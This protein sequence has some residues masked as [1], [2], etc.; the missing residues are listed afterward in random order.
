MNEMINDK[1]KN[2]VINNKNIILSITLIVS[3]V[4][5]SIFILKRI[6]K[7]DVVYQSYAIELSVGDI[8]EVDDI[9][10]FTWISSNN[11]IAVIDNNYIKAK[12]KGTT[13]ITIYKNKDVVC[14]YVVKVKEKDVSNNLKLTTLEILTN[15]I[16]IPVDSNYELE[17][18]V[19]P[20]NYD[21]SK[22]YWTISDES[23]ATIINGVVTG[24]KEGNC[25]ISV[26]SNNGLF[27]SCNV[28]V[29]NNKKVES[30]SLTETDK[31]IYIGEG[32]QIKASIVPEDIDVQITYSSSNTNIATVSNNGVVKG[33][34]EGSTEITVSAE[35][36]KVILKLNVMKKNKE[37]TATFNANGAD[38]VG[39]SIEKCNSSNDECKI[40]MPS[41]N[42]N[43]YQVI[44]WSKDKNAHSA[45]YKVGEKVTIY[46]N[47]TYYAITYKTLT[48][49][50][51]SNR[52]VISKD[53]ETCNIYN[54]EQT[55]NIQTPSISRNNYSVIGWGTSSDASKAVA[56]SNTTISISSPSSYYALTKINTDGI[57]AG[58]TGWL[59]TNS[60]YY[61]SASRGSSKTSISV[62][63]AF[64]I[65]GV[66]GDFFKVSVPN[67]SGYKYIEYK[68]V[69]INLSDYIP[70]MYFEIANASSSIYKSSGYNLPGVTGTKLYAT[71]KLY[72][73]RLRKSEY[74]VPI[75]YIVAKKLLVAQR[76][77]QSQGYSIKV[78]DTYR[79]RSV[80]SKIYSSLTNLYDSNQVVRENILYSYGL[81]GTRYTWGKSW[82]LAPGVSKHNTGSAIDMTLVY[83]ST[84]VEV[85]MPTPMH[86]LSTKAI[87]YYAPGISLI[88]A[89]YS[90]EMNDVAKIMD[91]V[92]TKAGLTT[93][94]SEW[95]HFQD[96]NAHSIIL[97][98]QSNGCDFSVTK[99]YS[100]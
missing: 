31:K 78:Y 1:I 66:E 40:T 88:P 73:S 82:F 8:Y 62:G 97:E 2:F 38:N 6:S 77:L 72:N 95:W 60:Y 33:I 70:S 13:I 89:N 71:G 16:T 96:S 84:G 52:A 44:G 22:L 47:V 15:E 10:D 68:Y 86:E 100:Y 74:M 23:V 20:D 50:F 27:S 92:L 69:M 24:K 63:T 18:R 55:C 85:T 75:L 35:N 29:I 32:Y 19:I 58:S 64:T 28:H 81:S 53:K 42:R 76:S 45:D 21:I 61:S 48:A 30:I 46:D 67:V 65:E 54:S 9:P 56:K 79:P 90:K 83:K 87:K 98:N 14:E 39:K 7:E 94:A 59:A 80:S 57:E 41:I 34:S 49:T 4:T 93:L 36:K 25:V 91:D 26:K 37:I 5:I 51:N 99:L 12:S 11:D 17:L 43:G 3:I